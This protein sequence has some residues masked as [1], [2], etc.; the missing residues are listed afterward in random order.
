MY[1]LLNEAKDKSISINDAIDLT[2]NRF[3][4]DK[5]LVIS[6]LISAATDPKPSKYLLKSLGIIKYNIY[7]CINNNF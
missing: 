2:Q 5:S 4:E 1:D 7:I 6:S 3:Q